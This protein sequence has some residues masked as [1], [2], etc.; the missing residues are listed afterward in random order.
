MIITKKE[1]EQLTER[2]HEL[3]AHV[4]L[5]DWTFKITPA[6]TNNWAEIHI[7]DYNHGEIIIGPKFIAADEK[8]RDQ[9]LLHELMHCHTQ[10]IVNVYEEM[11]SLVHMNIPDILI[12]MTAKTVH[13][14]EEEVVEGLAVAVNRLIRG[15]E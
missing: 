3:A 13:Q 4:A 1:L 6:K 2:V 7:Q 14:R 9:T 11:I 10:R 8:T 5:S 12:K 15:E